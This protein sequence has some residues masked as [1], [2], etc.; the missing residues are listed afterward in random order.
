MLVRQLDPTEHGLPLEI[1]AFTN[2]TRWVVYE[3]IQADIF[4]H[5]VAIAGQFDL[6]IFQQPSGN[7]LQEALARVAGERSSA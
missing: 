3:G 4:D 5:L 7:D 1:Y 2:D 6:R